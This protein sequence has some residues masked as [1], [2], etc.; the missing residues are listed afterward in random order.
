MMKTTNLTLERVNVCA[1]SASAL[2]TNI[3][4]L[5]PANVYAISIK[6]ARKSKLMVSFISRF[7]TI[8]TVSVSA[9]LRSAMRASHGT[10]L[11]VPAHA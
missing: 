1:H 11:T 4:T 7:G 6:T 2:S 10:L 8:E 5:I 9:F 3:G